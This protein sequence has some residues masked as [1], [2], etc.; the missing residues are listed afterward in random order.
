MILEAVLLGLSTGTYC[1]MYCGPVLIPFLFGTEKNSCR[2]NAGLIGLFLASRL[3]MY[4]VLGV[5]LS[6]AGLLASEFFDPYFAR[7][8]SVYAYILCGTA[9]LLN[10]F[11]AK[12]P[13]KKDGCKCAGLK[14][15]GNDFLTAVFAGFA[16]GLHICAPLW[17][18]IARSVFFANRMKGIFYLVFFYVG[19]LPFFLPLFGIPFV[20]KMFPVLKRISRIAQLLIGFYFLIFEGLIKLF[21]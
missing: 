15:L 2:R 5:A 10:S 20:Q 4:F 12:F 18:A 1:A 13:W 8:L 3:A 21:F 17:T 6:A 14:K 11:G 9:L 16:V 7:R 19:T